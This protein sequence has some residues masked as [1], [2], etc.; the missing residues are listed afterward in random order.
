MNAY[1]HYYSIKPLWSEN[2]RNPLSGQMHTD[3]YQLLIIKYYVTYSQIIILYEFREFERD[4]Y[5]IMMK[6]YENTVKKQKK[7]RN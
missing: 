4:N 2:N 1:T 3:D 7:L 5:H 6:V